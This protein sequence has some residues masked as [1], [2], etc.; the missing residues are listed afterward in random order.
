[1]LNLGASGRVYLFSQ[2]VDFRKAHDG[3]CSLIR[4]QLRSNPFSGDLYAFFNRGK[5]RIKILVWDQN[6]FWMLYKRLE[7][8][9]FPFRFQE[10]D[11]SVE[12]ERAQLSMLLAGIEWKNVK[13]SSRFAVEHGITT[14]DGPAAQPPR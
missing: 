2:P 5:D 14:R 11:S 6:G 9:S 7:K 3:L 10:D 4:D 13:R 1:M 8:G 12:I